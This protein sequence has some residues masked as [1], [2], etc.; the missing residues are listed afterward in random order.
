[1]NHRTCLA[2]LNDLIPSRCTMK[3][4]VHEH[5]CG[6]EDEIVDLDPCEGDKDNKDG[7]VFVLAAG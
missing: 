7:L 1:M 2:F 3:Y 5:V 6:A 4:R